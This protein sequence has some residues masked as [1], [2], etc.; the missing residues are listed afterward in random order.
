[1]KIV[2]YTPDQNDLPRLTE[3]EESTLA[4]LSDEQIDYSDIE[5]LNEDF[6]E[7]AERRS[8]S[9]LFAP[10]RGRVNYYEDLTTPTTEE[11]GL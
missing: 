9:D 5:E 3:A 4:S 11:W 1:M 2:N 7:T 6:W 8:T 10:L